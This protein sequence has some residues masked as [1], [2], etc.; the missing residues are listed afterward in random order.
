MG[1]FKVRVLPSYDK[2][3]KP[4]V[5]WHCKRPVRLTVSNVGLCRSCVEGAR[6]QNRVVT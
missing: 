6:S 3:Y 4:K 2:P 5:C 1:V